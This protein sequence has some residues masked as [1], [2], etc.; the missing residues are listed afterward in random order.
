MSA[1]RILRESFANPEKRITRAIYAKLVAMAPLF[2]LEVRPVAGG[3]VELS[4]QGF[5]EGCA[6]VMTPTE[7]KV[8]LLAEICSIL[9]RWVPFNLWE[10]CEVTLLAL[11]K[12]RIE[13]YAQLYRK[14]LQQEARAL[15]REFKNSSY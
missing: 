4:G 10:P 7:A 11:P 15:A 3:K 12:S 1:K 13:R 8:R 2:H 6:L 9:S 5:S 14:A